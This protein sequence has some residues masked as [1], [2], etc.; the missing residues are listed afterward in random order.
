MIDWLQYHC[1]PYLVIIVLTL[2]P[3]LELRAS[4]PYGI[5]MAQK[6]WWAVFVLAVVTNIL[7]G[8]VVYIM[9][10][11]FLH[12]LLRVKWIDRLWQRMVIKTQ[13]KIHAKVEK[14]GVVGLGLFIGVPLPGSGV[15]SGAAGGYVL[16]FTHR[17]FLRATVLGILIAGIVVLVVTLFCAEALSFL[18]KVPAA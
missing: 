8:P 16:G 14:Y 4:I 13:K 6:E 9:L 10:D 12:L 5:L 17:E 15:Y 18:I 1:D 2:V 3:A 7:L 11:K